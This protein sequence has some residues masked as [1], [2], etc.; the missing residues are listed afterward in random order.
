M[1]IWQKLI[2]VMVSGATVWGLSYISSVKP[3]MAMM[4]ASVN[5][6]VVAVCSY[7]TSFP[8]PKETA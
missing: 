3:D 6:A 8:G 7:F 5:A 2:I 1:K 4:L